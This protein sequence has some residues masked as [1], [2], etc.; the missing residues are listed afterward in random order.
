MLGCGACYCNTCWYMLSDFAFLICCNAELF[1]V[2]P[3]TSDCMEEVSLRRVGI[4]GLDVLSCPL[5][6]MH[7]LI[8][9]PFRPLTYMPSNASLSYDIYQRC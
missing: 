9:L 1:L 3:C 7:V 8:V 2:F 4:L 5:T 6:L